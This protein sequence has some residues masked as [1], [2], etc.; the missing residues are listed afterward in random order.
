M[1]IEL[2]LIVLAMIVAF[3]IFFIGMLRKRKLDLKYCIVWLIALLGMTVYCISPQLLRSFADLLGITTS[4]NALF[5]V[6][7]AFLAFICINLTITVSK[8]SE[9]IKKLTQ[10]VAIKEF[11]EKEK[12]K[13]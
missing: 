10:N 8:L 2:R 5:L 12:D 9:K 13:T 4:V 11:E 6:C 1:L 7:I 3:V